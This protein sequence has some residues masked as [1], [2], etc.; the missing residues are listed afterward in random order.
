MRVDGLMHVLGEV[1]MACVV[2][3][4]LLLLANSISL[5]TDALDEQ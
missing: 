4:L 3:W 5:S 2:W 1:G